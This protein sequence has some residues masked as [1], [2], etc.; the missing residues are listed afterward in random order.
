MTTTTDSRAVA[1]MDLDGVQA[2][3]DQATSPDVPLRILFAA[4]DRLTELMSTQAGDRHHGDDE[5]VGSSTAT[6]DV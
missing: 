6:G 2:L 1:A 5:A 3:I 4:L